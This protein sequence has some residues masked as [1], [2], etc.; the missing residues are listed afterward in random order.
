MKQLLEAKQIFDIVQFYFNSKKPVA[1][2]CHGVIT[3]CRAGVLKG[4][5]TTMLPKYMERAAYLSTWWKLGDHYR[6]YAQYVEDEVR[7]AGAVVHVG[8][9]TLF[10]RGTRDNDE[11]AFV[12]EDQHYLSGRW[13]GDAYLLAKKMILLL[14]QSQDNVDD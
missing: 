8:P 13:P 10:S 1:A 6:T 9:T 5:K 3:A 11:P 2:I 4:I 7:Q 14:Q 12:V